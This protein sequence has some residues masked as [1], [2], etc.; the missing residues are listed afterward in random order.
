[1][2]LLETS[3]HPGVNYMYLDLW[4]GIR[5]RWPLDHKLTETTVPVK[6]MTQCEEKGFEP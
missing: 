3:F 6:S 4:A 5:A 1:M 2:E